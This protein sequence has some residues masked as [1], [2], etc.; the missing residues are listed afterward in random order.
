MGSLRLITSTLYAMIRRL[1]LLR[2]QSHVVSVVRLSWA[3]NKN[4]TRPPVST[5]LRYFG[6]AAKRTAAHGKTGFTLFH[7]ISWNCGLWL[8]A[9]RRRTAWGSRSPRT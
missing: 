5:R 1:V 8:P 9:R 6:A 7:K 4:W 2:G 3:D